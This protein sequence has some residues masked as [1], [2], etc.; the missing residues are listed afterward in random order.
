M[1]VSRAQKGPWTHNFMVWFFSILFV[2]LFYWL[3]GFI[4]RDI[5]TW[6]GPDY[7]AI[8]KR[9]VSDQLLS[10]LASLAE[11]IQGNKR[12]EAGLKQRQTVLR[13]STSNSEKTMNQLLELQRATMQ[14]GLTPSQE[15]TQALAQSQKLFLTN[16]TKYQELN[17]QIAV[18]NE[19]L[20]TLEGRQ[21]D[22]EKRLENQRPAVRDEYSRLQS[23]HQFRL[24]AFKLSLLVPLLGVAV[25]LFLKQR[26]RAYAPLVYGFGLALLVKVFEVMHQHFPTRYFKYILIVIRLLRVVRIL[27]YLLRITAFPK[28]DWLLRQYRE[29][30]EHFL[31]PICE[32]PIRRGPLQ[33]LFWTRRTI[34]KLRLPPL[35]ASGPDA[36]YVCPVCATRLFEVCP[37]CKGIR[38]SLLPACQ[39]C[40]AEKALAPPPAD[41]NAVAGAVAT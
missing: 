16:Q 38:H 12:A 34:K 28:L 9:L 19:Q 26:G 30:Y 32:H 8:E 10:E 1:K 29:A 11:Q 39:H 23:H 13:D 40:G 5:S 4:V 18:L 41:G 7:Q 37:S 33:H 21:R 31:C 25:W 27:I 22:A 14:K 3:L 36:P 15:E 20:A 2:V 24:A 6:P 17:D 35:S